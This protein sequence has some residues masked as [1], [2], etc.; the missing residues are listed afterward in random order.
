MRASSTR[1][2]SRLLDEVRPRIDAVEK[3]TG[4]ALF[5]ADMRLPNLVFGKVLHSSLPHA[6]IVHIDTSRARAL[7]GVFAVLTGEDVP[8]VTGEFVYDHPVLARD[9][10]RFVGEPVAAVAAV[11]G[12]TAEEAV[13]LIEVEYEELP[14]VLDPLEALR[15]ESPLVHEGLAAYEKE[16]MVNSVAGTNICNSVHLKKG[17]VEEGFAKSDFVFEETFSTPAVAHAA[18]EPYCSIARVESNGRI[19]IWSANDSPH[20]LKSSLARALKVEPSLIRVVVPYVGG[21]FGG[22]GLRLEGIAVALAKAVTGRAV[23]LEYTREESFTSTVVSHSAVTTIKTGVDRNGTIIA[24]Q[25]KLVMDAGAYAEKGPTVLLQGCRGAPGPYRIP[26][27]EIEGNLVYTNKIPADAYRGFGFFQ[28]Q[29]AVESQMDIIATGLHMDPLEFRMRNALADGDVGPIGQKVVSCGLKECLEKVAEAIGWREPRD[30]GVGIGIAC[31]LKNTRTPTTSAVSLT[32]GSDGAVTV[33][34][35]LVEEGQGSKHVM[36]K[37]A[38]SELGVELEKVKVITSDT[39]LTPWDLGTF[40][41]RSVFSHGNALM[42]AIRKAVE[43]MKTLAAKEFGVS[44]SAVVFDAGEFTIAGAPKTTTDV[45]AR[46]LRPGQQLQTSGWFESRSPLPGE[47]GLSAFWIYAANGAKVVV[48]KETGKVRL[49]KVVIAQD[50]GKAMDKL[51]TNVQLIGGTVQGIGNTISEELKFDQKGKLRN[52]SFADY[53]LPTA[54][55]VPDELLPIIVEF[56]HPEGPKGAKGVG[57]G[58]L[59]SIQA[60]LANAIAQA[61]GLRLNSFPITPEKLASAALRTRSHSANKTRRTV[62][63]SEAKGHHRKAEG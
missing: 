49:L 23:K 18:L 4:E 51:L 45:L 59:L 21:N 14:Y 2:G 10:V 58:S 47:T 28:G 41:S 50:V 9:V 54:Q 48:D 25:M 3:V 31:G 36:A 32:V 52:P 56:P 34:T 62:M 44:Y 17:D 60:A 22:K 61:S 53:S 63:T 24:R 30:E 27:V 5:V 37:L 20:R 57:E 26:N 15:K 6:R 29:F 12:R 55:D 46:I 13:S 40:S 43:Q 42:D 39:D 11:D 8:I 19:T 16:K 7:P 35:S 33:Y 1:T 38:A